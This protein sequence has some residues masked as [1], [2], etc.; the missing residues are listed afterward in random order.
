MLG[1]TLGPKQPLF[2]LVQE[3]TLLEC[4]LALAATS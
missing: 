4:W 3:M 1:K 2:Q